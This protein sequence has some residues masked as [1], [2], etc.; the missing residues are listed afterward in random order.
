MTGS[1]RDAIATV[2]G[3]LALEAGLAIM[4]A[5]SAGA[6]ATR[7]ADGSPV[8]Q[9]DLAADRCIRAGL[10]RALPDIA[11]V[12]EEE[13]ATHGTQT[14]RFILVDPLDGT[15]EFVAGRD[16]FTVNIALIESGVP[17]AGAVYAPALQRLYV[18]GDHAWRG[19]IAPD[20]AM[21]QLSAMQE[22]G[23]SRLPDRSWRAV[24]SRSHLDA[25]TQ[26]WLAAQPIG[27]F[28]AAGSSLKFC[29]I[30]EGGADVYPR[31]S[32]TMEWD[33]AAGD[34]ILRAAGGAVEM[35]DGRPLRYGK[36]RDAFRNPPFIAW[37]QRPSTDR[38]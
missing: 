21:P 12:T 31:M 34:A 36:Q 27:E 14:D 24:A 25:E 2:F 8:T 19:E 9:A 3:T 26:R 23:A 6:P 38:R 10:T 5:R 22:I 4:Q 35:I 20:A 11:I 17:V 37:G 15:R 32:P 18:A 16:E 30:A 13:P 33:T 1:E 28:C 29:V 7:K